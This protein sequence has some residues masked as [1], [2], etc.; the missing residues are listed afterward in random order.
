MVRIRVLGGRTLYLLTDAKKNKA[1]EM[2]NL[3]IPKRN[4]EE[5]K[6]DNSV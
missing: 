4:E 1:M 5:G 6:G 2:N 3:E